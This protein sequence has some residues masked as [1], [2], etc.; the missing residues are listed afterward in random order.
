MNNAIFENA[1]MSGRTFEDELQGTKFLGLRDK[2]E[3]ILNQVKPYCEYKQ[4]ISNINTYATSLEQLKAFKQAIEYTHSY[5]GAIECSRVSKMI[6][7]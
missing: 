4:L 2:D 6:K 3:A 5:S 7:G 1:K